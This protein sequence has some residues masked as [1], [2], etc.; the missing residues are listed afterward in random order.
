MATANR[1]LANFDARISEIKIIPENSATKIVIESKM[2]DQLSGES[3]IVKIVFSNVAAIDFRINF[4]DSAVG[5][6]A[7]GLYQIVEK[8]FIEKLVQEIFERRKAI[9]LLEGDYDYCENDPGDLL[10][11]FDVY[12]NFMPV[13]NNYRVFVQNVDAGVYIVVAKDVQIVG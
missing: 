8:Q 6:E 13:I 10:N 11:T 9:Y 2:R 3:K 12:E 4:F 5:S 1:I 7:A